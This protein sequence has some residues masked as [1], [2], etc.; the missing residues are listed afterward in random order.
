MKTFIFFIF[1]S[2]KLMS[3][4]AQ[5]QELAFG[6]CFNKANRKSIANKMDNFLTRVSQET[7]CSKEKW[8]CSRKMCLRLF[9]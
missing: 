7:G 6:N 8:L 3:V 5:S 1:L 4:S 9:Y 2:F